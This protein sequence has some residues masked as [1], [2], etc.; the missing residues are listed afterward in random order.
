MNNDVDK[1]PAINKGQ[2]NHSHNCSSDCCNH[3]HTSNLEIDC[4]NSLESL[5]INS[6]EISLLREFGLY[7]Y[8][9]VSRFIMSSSVEKEAWTVSLAPVYI[10]AIDDSMDTVKEIG[11]V[12][13]ALEKKGVI[14]LDYDIPLQDYDYIQHTKSTLFSFFKETVNEGKKNPSFLF[15][16]AEI[17]L[18]SIALTEFGKSVAENI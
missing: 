6:K 5:T 2:Q 10:N 13:T 14:S 15:D 1:T 4:T 3:S 16:I 17:E 7:I 8:L 11:A 18:G 9:P 12:L